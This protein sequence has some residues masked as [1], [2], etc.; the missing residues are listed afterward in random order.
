MSDNDKIVALLESLIHEMR[1]G[2]AQTHEK[3][4]RVARAVAALSR[5]FQVFR[6]HSMSQFDR[7]GARIHDIESARVPDTDPAPFF[8]S[9][10]KQ[11]GGDR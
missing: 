11:A 6:D 8:D 9:E 1:D 3:V 10:A 4:D 7:Q 2:F 5:D